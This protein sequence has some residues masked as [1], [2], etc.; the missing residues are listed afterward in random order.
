MA[1]CRWCSFRNMQYISHAK[2]LLFFSLKNMFVLAA[3]TKTGNRFCA[4][5]TEKSCLTS[6][7]EIVS[8]CK[9]AFRSSHTRLFSSVCKETGNWVHSSLKA[10]QVISNS[11]TKQHLCQT[12]TCF[13]L[14]EKASPLSIYTGLCATTQFYF[15]IV[16]YKPC[17]LTK[18]KWGFY[19]LRHSKCLLVNLIFSHS[20]WRSTWSGCSSVHVGSAA[21]SWTR[22]G[23]DIR[24]D[25]MLTATLGLQNY[26]QT[27]FTDY[28]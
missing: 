9:P 2:Y 13:H 11:H 22:R 17:Y 4:T 27:T 6:V 14:N 28:Q 25:F 18:Q 23:R 1:L 7:S 3:V 10:H 20:F 12:W 21:P 26:I 15:Y 24:A 16:F 8:S 5:E 19:K